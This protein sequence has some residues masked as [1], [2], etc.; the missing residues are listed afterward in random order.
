MAEQVPS[1]EPLPL[2]TGVEAIPSVYDS[3]WTPR[4][5][6]IE[7]LRTALRGIQSCGTCEACR[8]AA[9]LALK[10]NV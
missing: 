6:E 1:K 7:R 9:T 10:G 3:N 8:N 2:A 5:D 4:T